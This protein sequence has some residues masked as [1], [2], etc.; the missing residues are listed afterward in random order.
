MWWKLKIQVRTFSIAHNNNKVWTRVKNHSF[1]NKN[2][3]HTIPMATLIN[4]LILPY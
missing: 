4:Y 2:I 1:I 3:R